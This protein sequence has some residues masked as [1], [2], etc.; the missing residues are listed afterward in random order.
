MSGSSAR[1][2]TGPTMRRARP[3]LQGHRRAHPGP[4]WRFLGAATPGTCAR[5]SA[6]H[7]PPASSTPSS[8][9][10]SLAVRTREARR[11]G[12]GATS[13]GRRSE[14]P[15]GGAGGAGR[16]DHARHGRDLRGHRLPRPRST[17]WELS[18]HSRPQTPCTEDRVDRARHD[19][20][21][22]GSA[23]VLPTHSGP[24]RSPSTIVRD[25]SP[26]ATA[27]GLLGFVSKTDAA[28]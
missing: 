5:H 1:T 23:A 4:A 27:A 8:G 3:I 7:T 11:R 28:S 16:D 24:S 14:P 26:V 25:G 20:E 17:E 6:S 2:G 10:G 12:R 9:S 21:V 15:A 19:G 13:R 22:V 18:L